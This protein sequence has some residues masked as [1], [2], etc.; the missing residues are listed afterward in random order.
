[1]TAYCHYDS[2]HESMPNDEIYR[3]EHQ[4]KDT[5]DLQCSGTIVIRIYFCE[6]FLK[7]SQSSIYHG[8]YIQMTLG[9]EDIKSMI[10]SP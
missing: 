10:T 9:W 7:A 8:L 4:R 1:V 2:W 5:G 6:D 3:E